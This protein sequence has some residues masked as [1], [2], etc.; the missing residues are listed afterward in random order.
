MFVAL[1]AAVI[2]TLL[3]A[4]VI[5]AD[6]VGAHRYNICNGLSNQLLYH[7]AEI[8]AA[9]KQGEQVVEVPNYY[10]VDGAQDTDENVLPSGTNSVPFEVAFDAPYFVKKLKELGIRAK[11]VQF[12]F[13]REQ[14][15]CTGIGSLLR[16]DPT[17][18][19]KILSFFR[20]SREMKQLLSGILRAFDD[21]G[22]NDGVCVHHRDGQDWHD[23]CQRWSSINDGA[24]R[25][26]C[27]GVPGHSFL[28][29]LEA[30][31]LESSRWVYYC[32]DHDIPED[33]QMSPYSVYSRDSLMSDDDRHAVEAI[34]DGMPVRDLWALLD[35]YACRELKH[36]IGNSVSTFS[37]IQIAAREG[38]YAFWYNSQSIPLG[39]VWNVYKMPLVYTYTEMSAPLGKHFLKS[40]ILSVRQ[41]M[42]E[43]K[44][45]ILYH[46]RADKDF[47]SWLSDKDVDIH[48]HDPGWRDTIETMR[49]H[50]NPNA[51]HLFLHEGNY[52]GTWQRIDIPK[53]V[54]SEYCLYLDSDTILT[55]PFTLVDFGL[56]LTYG[57]AMSAELVPENV[58]LNAGVTLINIPRMRETYD[59][60]LA[61]IIRHSHGKRFNHPAPSDQGA[62]LDFYRADVTFLSMLFNYK[63]Y[64]S[65]SLDRDPYIIHFHGPKPHDYIG[66]LM[67]E[68]CAEAFQH[69]CNK[70]EDM[71]YLCQ[72]FQ[73]FARVS[74]ESAPGMY[75]KNSFENRKQELLCNRILDSF[76]EQ[77]DDCRSFLVRLRQEIVSSNHE[78]V[79]LWSIPAA[80]YRLMFGSSFLIVIFGTFASYVKINPFQF[81]ISLLQPIRGKEKSRKAKQKKS[82]IL[83]ILFA[84]LVFGSL[85][86]LILNL[87]AQPPL[88]DASFVENLRLLK[89]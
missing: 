46:G 58:P 2:G 82:A 47:R 78:I 50:G 62:Y 55:Q 41:H 49:Q 17:D 77:V 40:S 81:L 11:L 63:P 6:S 14:I 74:N 26:N 67:G 64:W 28:Q 69:I 39:N 37:A 34:K 48:D 30:R 27:L 45:H 21:Y 76:L 88:P 36:F 68:P 80:G 29:S 35:F 59:D 33:L 87:L 25:G 43:N 44:I 65:L 86:S 51:S 10:I 72:S 75:C 70:I 89:N 42:P 57:I 61:F 20:P 15:E 85:A 24:Y 3:L 54:N 53:V 38:E 12:D 16:A 13:S 18:V 4:L 5:P 31:G 60:F 84:V 79:T 32:G 7:S 19:N 22:V 83:R 73:I 52:F 9:L 8:A 56:D 66:H 1:V 23:H 71:P